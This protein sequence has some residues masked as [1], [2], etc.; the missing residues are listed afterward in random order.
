MATS[1]Y[2]NGEWRDGTVSD[3][4]HH[5]KL[6]VRQPTVHRGVGSPGG[7]KSKPP[8]DAKPT[9]PSSGSSDSKPSGS[10]STD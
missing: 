3:C 7:Y 5:K 8:S 10:K 6:S 4:P 9:P 1:H 2:C